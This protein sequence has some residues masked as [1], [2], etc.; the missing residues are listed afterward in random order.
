MMIQLF[1][2][3]ESGGFGDIWPNDN[4]KVFF[5]CFVFLAAGVNVYALKIKLENV[6][7]HQKLN[8]FEF[9]RFLRCF[10]QFIHLE[11]S[12]AI[13]LLKSPKWLLVLA[14]TA[15]MRLAIQFLQQSLEV[16]ELAV[17]RRS[18]AIYVTCL[19]HLFLCCSCQ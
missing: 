13:V 4:G 17:K 11:L 19:S 5:F 8:V 1:N 16:Y 7:N 12:F 3:I 10:F 9:V 14:T 15:A 6:S 2:R 18:K